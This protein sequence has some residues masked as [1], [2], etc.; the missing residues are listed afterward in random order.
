[1][2]KKDELILMS[3][4]GTRITGPRADGLLGPFGILCLAEVSQETW[5]AEGVLGQDDSKAGSPLLV[6]VFR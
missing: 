3:W 2:L 5:L 1:M 6:S 4:A